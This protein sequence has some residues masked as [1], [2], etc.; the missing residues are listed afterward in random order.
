M[1]KY[2][3]FLANQAEEAA[4]NT[5][6]STAG[7]ID[8]LNTD[9]NFGI[10]S[11]YMSDRFGMDETNYDRSEIIDS[12]VNNMRK[13]NFGQSVVTGT[14]L[15]HLYNGDGE[16][17]DQRRAI[18]GDAYNLFDSLG[19]LFQDDNT[20]WQKADGV[21]DYARAL[22]VDPVNVVSLGAGKVAGAA[23][24]RTSVT[25]VKDLARRAAAAAVKTATS[26]GV[27]GE[28]LE[29][30]GREAYR[31]GLREALETIGT[32]DLATKEVIST[33]VVDAAAAVG[34][35]M[36][37]QEARQLA[38]VQEEFDPIQAAIAA[39]GGAV[40][41]GLSLGVNA[42]RGTSGIRSVA[43]AV[44]KSDEKTEEAVKRISTP[45]G[46]SRQLDPSKTRKTL[47]E[48][49]I[50]WR[51]KVAAGKNIRG[52]LNENDL[53][54]Y[55]RD[56]YLYF[57]EGLR[58]IFKESGVDID[59][60][61][62][63]KGQRRT[64]WVIDVIKDESF[65]KAVREDLQ[66]LYDETVGEA[67]GI[68]MELEDFLLARADIAS[69]H[70]R[71]LRS[72][73]QAKNIEAIIGEKGMSPKK[74]L[75]A[76][77]N[78]IP[79]AIRDKIVNK[80]GE[81]QHNFIRM[82]VT[83]PGTTALNVLG[84]GAASLNQSYADML[85][86]GLYGGASTANM[87]VGRTTKAVDYRNAA[88]HMA[89]LQGQKMRNLADPQGTYDE[90]MD[91]LTLRPDAQKTMFRYLAGGIE[92]DEI[93]ADLRNISGK[94]LDRSNF[95]KFQGVLETAYGVKAQDMITKTQEFMY[96]ID[97]QI[98]LKYGMTYNEFM[99]QENIGEI[100]RGKTFKEFSEVEATA[101]DDTLRNVYAKKYGDTS[102]PKAVI[103]NVANIIEKARNFPVIG[104]MIPFGQFFNNTMGF[105]FD[106]TGISIAH[107]IAAGTSR[108]GMELA[109]KAAV[110]WVTIGAA[111]VKSQA[112][113][114]EG[115]AWHEER[116]EDGDIRTRLY[117]YPLSFFM[118]AGRI[119]AHIM[120]D[121]EVPSE[122]TEE[123]FR[124]FG[125]EAVTRQLGDAGATVLN[126]ITLLTQGEL[127]E[128][129]AAG[130]EAL[131]SA[132]GM[133]ASGFTRFADPV[134]TM[135]ALGEGE[136]Y[137]SPNRSIGNKQYN[138]AIRYTDRIIDNMIGL[139]NLEEMTGGVLDASGYDVE[140]S[141]AVHGEE[142]ATPVGRIFGYRSVAP[143]STVQRMFRDIGRPDWQT[144][145]KIKDPVALQTFNT[146]IF[147]ILESM[148][149]R[150]M[151]T[152]NWEG[153]DLQ[154]KQEVL[155][156]LLSRAREETKEMLRDFPAGDGQTAVLIYDINGQKSS[157][158]ARKYRE[159]LSDFDINETE[160]HTLSPL[161]LEFL[162]DYLKEES[163]ADREAT[164]EIVE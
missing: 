137:V 93:V 15:A 5:P 18:A 25:A 71:G 99:S 48:L 117:D 11:R 111:A 49:L 145:I 8:D 108:D 121:E 152:S 97:K 101:L 130:K 128:S 110:G 140:K 52:K 17:L 126:A 46:A 163:S 161:Q 154:R 144:E 40:G 31:R 125:T 138:N 57:N 142:G 136:G 43:L 75:E 87:L 150:V 164:A 95:M 41:A 147:P 133:Y 51:Q 3:D 119:G 63:K 124:T 64:G 86:A 59:T 115:L 42:L 155:K 143:T 134:N 50:P 106:H 27:A 53:E 77:I 123:A 104:A 67:T 61:N 149:D 157:I 45:E 4:I 107:K 9:E 62:P 96:A 36:G 55:E 34:V 22:I 10:I 92:S 109:T 79:N 135:L 80:A 32:R 23:A 72:L 100:M 14:E 98:R 29:Q 151:A 153:M 38:G 122:L 30:T 2:A 6:R 66:K 68:D 60:I 103:G 132:M 94:P 78:P 16:Q 54:V 19:N 113:L 44:A 70:A 129:R 26:R 13:F 33:G 73:R 69:E 1:G 82:L 81:V 39:A 112:S 160:L 159:V 114:E 116:T 58:Q 24:A 127:E 21:R 102:N 85:R 118:M 65:P 156:A 162:L 35:D 120:R 76:V 88:R 141:F 37:F 131:T 89:T 148:T 7:S 139:E 105:M 90:V 20:F 84:W 56:A 74:H 28:A 158:G 12:Y 83:H 47:R 91:Y 146:Y